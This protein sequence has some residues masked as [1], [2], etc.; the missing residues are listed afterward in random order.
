MFAYLEHSFLLSTHFEKGKH[1]IWYASTV[2]KIYCFS[3]RHSSY[4][5]QS[6]GV[7]IVTWHPPLPP[8]C[9]HKKITDNQ[10]SAC[11]EMCPSIHNTADT[12]ISLT[13]PEAFFILTYT[14]IFRGVKISR[15][16][17]LKDLT[18]SFATNKKNQAGL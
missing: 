2:F 7:S 12:C 5:S 8:L 4:S 17:V 15:N 6:P 1:L 14:H 10:F 16:V 9:W 3:T 13:V 11:S 18:F